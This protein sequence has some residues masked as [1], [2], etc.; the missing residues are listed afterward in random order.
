[1]EWEQLLCE[2]RERSHSGSNPEEVRTEFQRDY[3]RIVGSASFRRLQDKTQVYPLGRGDFVRTRLTHS[4]EVSSFAGS[5]GD[6]I[7]RRLKKIGAPG[8]DDKVREDCCDILKCAG[9][10]HDIGNP[11][12]GH[13]GE[14][15]IRQW[16]GDNLGSLMFKGRKVSELLDAQ[17]KADLLNFEGNAQSLRVLARLHSIMGLERGMNLTY[18]LLNTIIKY[19]VGSLGIDKNSGDVRTKK[20][21]Y[22]RSEQELFEDITESTGAGQCRHPLTFILESADDTAYKTADIEDACVKKLLDCPRIIKELRSERYTGLCNSE[23]LKV[24]KEAADQLSELSDEADRLGADSI[25]A[26]QRWIIGL[27]STLIY[28]AAESF[29][30]NYAAIMSGCFGKDLLSAGSARVL[31]FAL[32]DIAYRFAFRSAMIVKQEIGEAAMMTALL[33][34]T[35]TAALRFDTEYEQRYDHDL[36]QV[37]SENYL[38][39]CRKSCEGSSDTEQCCYRIRFALDNISGMTD[40]YAREFYRIINGYD[41]GR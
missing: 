40:G 1:M 3:H 37:L 35:V 41:I 34:K 15:A 12:F 22:F 25:K 39:I 18:A 30:D 29:C 19:P 14:D 20:M 11:P 38:D 8:V 13:F 31:A 6:T 4:L 5:L 7:F 36:V 24:L 26:V 28:A 21:G 27:Q 16:F 32:G 10:I 9:L 23:E 33:D 2:K 17:M